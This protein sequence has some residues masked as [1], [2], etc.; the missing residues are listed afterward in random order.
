MK[1]QKDLRKIKNEEKFENIQRMKKI[2]VNFIIH[3]WK[4][5][6]IF[7]AG[8]QKRGNHSKRNIEQEKNRKQKEDSRVDNTSETVFFIYLIKNLL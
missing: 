7:F 5:W 1:F 8:L 3:H 4:I 2:N 6:N